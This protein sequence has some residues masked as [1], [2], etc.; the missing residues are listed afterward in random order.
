MGVELKQK[1]NERYFPQTASR[2][3]ILILGS[4]VHVE[5]WSN[6]VNFGDTCNCFSSNIKDWVNI[7]LFSSFIVLFSFVSNPE[8]W[9]V[10]CKYTVSGMHSFYKI[11]KDFFD[12]LL[13]QDMC[14]V[15][16]IQT[17]GNV[18]TRCDRAIQFWTAI[19]GQENCVNF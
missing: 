5:I 3:T 13:N 14:L 8:L 12:P 18:N 15:V 10:K 11:N 4:F 7:L 16:S 17:W 19:S 6:F 1:T 2:G 9:H